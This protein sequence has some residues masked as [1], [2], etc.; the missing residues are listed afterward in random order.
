MLLLLFVD[1][2]EVL[3]VS[4]GWGM[5]PCTASRMIFENG[6]RVRLSYSGIGR[7]STSVHAPGTYVIPACGSFEVPE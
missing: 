3:D 4:G 7:Y 1:Y 2:D 5:F 6:K